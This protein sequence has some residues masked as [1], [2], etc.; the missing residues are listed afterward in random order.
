[1]QLSWY[2]LSI[3]DTEIMRQV[4]DV[5]R[6][7]RLHLHPA[8]LRHELSVGRK[9]HQTRVAVA[10]NGKNSAY[11][12]AKNKQ[13]NLVWTVKI[14]KV[15]TLFFRFGQNDTGWKG[16]NSGPDCK[17]YVS[18]LICLTVSNI[19]RPIWY[20]GNGSWFTERTNIPAWREFLAQSKYL[21]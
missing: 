12:V 6:R 2:L 14:I 3:V 16:K 20:G 5:H 4:E 9:F 21:L 13:N 1:M 8:E 11:N 10:W 17:M 15:C 18:Y 7:I 19:K